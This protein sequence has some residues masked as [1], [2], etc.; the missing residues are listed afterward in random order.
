ME[1]FTADQLLGP[2]GLTVGA[3]LA[4]VWAVRRM[5]ILETRVEA[6]DALLDEAATRFTDCR[7][8]TERLKGQVELWRMQ[9]GHAPFPFAAPGAS[10]R[11]QAHPQGAPEPGRLNG[12]SG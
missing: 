10:G 12:S 5:L 8:E 7:L 4:L 2:T 6:R 9:A 3:V 1:F 11:Q